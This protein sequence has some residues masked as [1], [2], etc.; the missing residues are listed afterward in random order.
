[1][2]IQ[3]QDHRLQPI[4]GLHQLHASLLAGAR[5]R[6]QWGVGAEMEKLVVDAE[7]CE[8]A[9][10]QRIEAL[11]QQLAGSRNWQPIREQ[12]RLIGLQGR[13]SSVTLEP[14]GQLELSG[15]L[16]P[17]LYCCRGDFCRHVSDIVQAARPL[18]LLFLGL[19]VQPFTPLESID[20]LPKPR[21]AVMRAYMEQTGDMGQNMMKQSAGLQVNLDFA[22]EA[23]CIDKLQVAQLLAPV[24]YALFANSPL[25]DGR[26]SGFL[27]TR[28]EIWS[29]TDRDRVGL[30]PSLFDEGADLYS[31]IDYALDVPMYFIV[32]QGRLLDMTG[33]RFSFRR[34]MAEGFAGYSATLTDWDL[35]LSTLFPEVRLRPQ[36]ELRSADSLPPG[37]TLSVAALAKGLLYDNASRAEI[38]KLFRQC[39][40][41]ALQEI[42]RQSWRL[43]FKT[44]VGHHGLGDVARQALVLAREG[45]VRQQR[46]RNSQFDETLFL[47]GI[48][49]IA[50][51]GVTL[52]ERLL[53]R[54]HG[55]RQQRLAALKEHCGF[56]HCGP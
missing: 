50:A 45:L 19:G 52:A 47:D 1:M 41:A 39:D 20:W 40:V 36:I 26:P 21:Y 15:A 53:G 12:G 10:Y 32:R 33:E 56:H 5:P 42:Y 8:A 35:H 29:R 55:S 11:L 43:G 6:L 18:G 13:D 25:L 44:P 27:S 31:Y 34:Y 3:S 16:C 9:S 48:E 54:W 23:D 30:I 7:T 4:T 22:D 38:R 24:F 49:E 28:G 17:D 37:L 14:G 46:E 2:T 51:S